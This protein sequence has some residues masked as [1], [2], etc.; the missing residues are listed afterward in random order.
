MSA[1]RP[2]KRKVDEDENWEPPTTRAAQRRGAKGRPAA[3]AAAAMG[4]LP[5][6]G[7]GGSWMIRCSRENKI[8]HWD[9]GSFEAC[10]AVKSAAT[11]PADK[12]PVV[13]GSLQAANARA[14][15][16]QHPGGMAPARPTGRKFKP[17]FSSTEE[18]EYELIKEDEE[19]QGAKPD[20][21]GIKHDGSAGA[22]AAPAAAVES[23]LPG[24]RKRWRGERFFFADPWMGGELQNV[25]SCVETVEV[26]AAAA[27]G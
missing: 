20:G 17:L 18:D 24:G 12:Q 11:A 9:F 15:A 5:G 26:V 22:G 14:A 16:R 27:A 2:A 7:A 23:E 25:V 4:S 19:E 13:F 8:L 10:I 6:T 21:A 3:T 1:R